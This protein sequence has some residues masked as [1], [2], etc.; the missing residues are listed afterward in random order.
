MNSQLNSS[1][2]P[3]SPTADYTARADRGQILPDASWHTMP[4]MPADTQQLM[5]CMEVWGGNQ[6]ADNGVVMAGLDA[7]IYSKPYGDSAGGGDVY[8]VSSCATNRIL[9]L[10]IADV[11]GHGQAV[12]DLAAELRRLMRRYVNHL[13]HIQFVRSMNMQF[14]QLAQTGLFAT[15]VVST[16]FAPTSRLTLCNAGHPLPLFY[17]AATKQWT[18]L[19]EAEPAPRRAIKTKATASASAGNDPS[20]QVTNLP[21]GIMDIA[22]YQTF[23]VPLRVG[24]LV[25][26]YTDSLVECRDKD[27]EL[28]GQRGLLAIIKS[29]DVGDPGSL[30][31]KLIE[32]LTI[33]AGGQLAGDDVTALLFRPNGL[34][35]RRPS[36]VQ[37]LRAVGHIT[38]AI[39]RSFGPRGEPIPWPDLKLANIG[40]AI[41]GPLQRRWSA[42]DKPHAPR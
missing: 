26:C 16:F 12:Q 20:D 34:G 19:E 13:D 11:S 35:R 23:D 41:F 32:A 29:L 27:G 4:A 1:I 37:Q 3:A 25:L 42:N 9:R 21:L 6:A 24:D 39:A 36:L 31:P 28:L 5:Q 10:L 18:Y 14:A 33:R 2:L 7:W 8:Y 40:G 38:A 22:E 30:I 15:A 17:R